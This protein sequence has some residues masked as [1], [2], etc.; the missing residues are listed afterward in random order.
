MVSAPAVRSGPF[1]FASLWLVV[2][3]L[4]G[5]GIR[6]LSLNDPLQLTEFPSLHAVAERAGRPGET[7]PSSEPLLPVTSWSTVRERSVLPYGIEN[8]VPLYHYCLYLT[9]RYVPMTEWGLRFP[10]FIAGLCCIVGM[11][12]VCRRGLGTEASLIVALLV[13]VDPIQVSVSG[14]ARPYALGGLMCILSFLALQNLLQGSHGIKRAGNILVYGLTVALIGYLV[15]AMLL[16]WLA[17]AGVAVAGLRGSSANGSRGNSLIPWLAGSVLAA[18]LLIPIS[19]YLV[20]VVRFTAEHHE[21]LFLAEDVRVLGFLA[22]NSALVVGLVVVWLAGYVVRNI[23]R[24]EASDASLPPKA[25]NA[26]PDSPETLWMGRAWAFLPQIV[27]IVITFGLGY[28]L[29]LTPHLSYTTLGAAILLGFWATREPA[30]DLRLSISAAVVLAIA[31]WG[32]LEISS[33]V[34]LHAHTPAERM[35]PEINERQ[36]KGLWQPTDVLLVRSGF[37]EADFL[38]DGWPDHMRQRVEQALLSPYTTRYVSRQPYSIV[39]LSKSQYRNEVLQTSAGKGY[40]PGRFY[41]TELAERLRVF[42][43][44]RIASNDD[45]DRK[46]FFACLLPWLADSVGWDLSVARARQ[47]PEHYFDVYTG[48]NPEDYLAGLSDARKTDFTHL[49]RVRRLRPPWAFSLGAVAHAATA[50]S[51]ADLGSLAW[52][53]SQTKTPRLTR[54]PVDDDF[55][56]PSPP[57]TR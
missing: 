49:V 7:P 48:S 31:L 39:L 37:V 14:L 12:C 53:L 55:G 23:Q 10:S 34:G 21:H 4:V 13:A 5:A 50:G 36:A 46:E 20:A 15:P 24:Q 27:A 35:M 6:L 38:P 8:P 1:T 40:S 42:N 51:A 22:H 3:V 2:I 56:S 19:G 16:V 25:A 29:Y 17:H 26:L 57:A 32:R 45:P 18:L 11:Y 54:P 30:R 41:S 9:I 44:F 47:G 43:E 33:G 52:Q 28:P